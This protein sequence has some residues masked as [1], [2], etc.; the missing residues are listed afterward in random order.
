MKI[1]E[2]LRKC[3]AEQAIAEEGALKGRAAKPGIFLARKDHFKARDT[4][5]VAAT[6]LRLGQLFRNDPRQPFLVTLG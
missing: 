2:D 4:D 6:A 3:A 5:P 1:T